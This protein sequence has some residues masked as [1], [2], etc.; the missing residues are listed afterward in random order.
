MRR[1]I[2]ATHCGRSAGVPR[3]RV[4]IVPLWC[5]GRAIRPFTAAWLTPSSRWSATRKRKPVYAR[6]CACIAMIQQRAPVSATFCRRRVGLPTPNTAI[7]PSCGSGPTTPRRPIIWAWRCNGWT[8]WSRRK[9]CYRSALRFQPHYPEAYNNLGHLL[10][11]QARFAEAE[12]CY[13]EA[14]RQKPDYPQAHNDL[15]AALL[16]CGRQ[17]EA[18]DCFRAALRLKPDDPAALSN[19][20]GVLQE[21]GESG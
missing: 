4:A 3:L 2:S 15:G 1:S 12:V 7:V 20:G 13:R 19:L 9:S 10:Q 16:G 6:L 5:T 17:R 18:A 14:L 11:L 21:L 8:V